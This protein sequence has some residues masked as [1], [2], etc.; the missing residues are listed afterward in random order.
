MAVDIIS[1]GVGESVQKLGMVSNSLVSHTLNTAMTFSDLL[2]IKRVGE[3]GILQSSCL[4]Q[5][6]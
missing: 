1:W 4:L 5:M 3:G 2:W 6:M